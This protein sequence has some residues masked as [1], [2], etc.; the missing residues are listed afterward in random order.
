MKIFKEFHHLY[1]M[2]M[3]AGI[4]LFRRKNGL[5]VLLVHPGGPYFKKKDAGWWGIPKGELNEGEDMLSGARRE[6]REETG[7][8]IDGMFISLGGIRQNSYKRIYIWAVEGNWDGLLRGQ[9]FVKI[10]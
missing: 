5:E 6:L 4:L 8:E 7:I 9:S 2:K 10:E 3:S 1:R